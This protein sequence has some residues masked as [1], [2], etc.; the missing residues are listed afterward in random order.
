MIVVLEA[1]RTPNSALVFDWFSPIIF[2]LHH[3][4]GDRTTGTR[5]LAEGPPGPRMRYSNRYSKK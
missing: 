4:K 3:A 5:I 2:L 1:L